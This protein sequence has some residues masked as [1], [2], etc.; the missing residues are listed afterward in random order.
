MRLPLNRN[1]SLQVLAK[2]L[3]HPGKDLCSVFAPRSSRPDPCLT[4]IQ[5]QDR[6]LVASQ[7]SHQIPGSHRA[8][9]APGHLL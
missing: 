7:A 6:E 4:Q 3:P 2:P 9:Q 8:F 1:G 5:E